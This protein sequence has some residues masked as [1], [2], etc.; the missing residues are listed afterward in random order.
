MTAYIL[1]FPARWF[2][3]EG[4]GEVGGR[5][6][7]TCAPSECAPDPGALVPGVAFSDGL[8]LG[9]IQRRTSDTLACA[10]P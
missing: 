2:R 7:Y 8:N 3:C 9:T 4:R 10:Q 5:Q 6:L 1:S